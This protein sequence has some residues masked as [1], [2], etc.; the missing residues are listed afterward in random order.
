[1]LLSEILGKFVC[2]SCY[3]GMV[4]PCV[5]VTDSSDYK[6]WGRRLSENRLRSFNW[7]AE[8][9]SLAGM[10]DHGKSAKELAGIFGY[11]EKGLIRDAAL[12]FT[13]DLVKLS[14]CGNLTQDMA[15]RYLLPLR[16]WPADVPKNDKALDYSFYD[17][18]EVS[19]VI[20]LLVSGELNPAD[21]P[22][23]SA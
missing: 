16:V 23:E 6:D 4:I 3:G 5:I 19:A 17:Y 1:M 2:G 9:V 10:R 12:G 18:T 15:E 22:E 13:P 14:G 8:C 20:D 11:D 21:L 7:V